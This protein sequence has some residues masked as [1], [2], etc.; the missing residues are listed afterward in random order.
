MEENDIEEK[1]MI[2]YREDNVLLSRN[3]LF[4]HP[5]RELAKVFVY[6]SDY[7]FGLLAGQD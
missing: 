7:N 6:L 4:P 2:A 3:L 1:K 5:L